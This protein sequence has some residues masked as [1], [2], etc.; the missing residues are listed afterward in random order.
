M[1][2]SPPLREGILLKRYKR[3]LADIETDDGSQLTLHCPNTG[4]MLN[5]CE[6]GWRVW[7]SSSDN[8]KRK[9]PCTWELVEND[10]GALIGINT[11]QANHLVAEALRAG[12]IAE[13][14]GYDC[15]KRE[16]RFGSENS[17]IDFLLS[18]R[19]ADEAEQSDCY[20]EVK[21][22]TLG[23]GDGLGVFPDAVT[24]R[25]QKHLRELM[26]VIEQGERAVLLF[27]VQHSGIDQVSAADH[28]DADYGLLLRAAA[29]AGVELLAYK[30]ILSPREIRLSHRIPIAL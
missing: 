7:Y 8:P 11:G 10:N 20:L 22:V 18:G 14:K 30:A 13:L 3:F 6:P 21:S 12:I 9:Y 28:I 24:T 17:R 19:R 16:V 1:E 15:H 2:Y 25:G 23:M 27:C 5:C 4:S 26:Q 29:D